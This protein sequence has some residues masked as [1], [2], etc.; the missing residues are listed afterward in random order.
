MA[1]SYPIFID[2]KQTPAWY[3]FKVKAIPAM[4]LLDG[5]S[6]IVA[7]WTG[8]IDYKEME[9]EV[10]KRLDKRVEVERP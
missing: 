8:K 4:Y 5:E 1:V 10:L 7:Q 2:A 6:Q 9:K 3:Q